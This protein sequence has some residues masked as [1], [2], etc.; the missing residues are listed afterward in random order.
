MLNPQMGL[1]QIQASFYSI[2][3]FTRQPSWKTNLRLVPNFAS[4]LIF[5]ITPNLL[6]HASDRK[7]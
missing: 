5:N 7:L 2:L 4:H 1:A 3:R 6:P